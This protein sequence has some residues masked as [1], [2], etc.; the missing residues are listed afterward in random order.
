MTF[1]VEETYVA[2]YL[3]KV[4]MTFNSTIFSSALDHLVHINRDIEGNS[5]VIIERPN[6]W[7]TAPQPILG[8]NESPEGTSNHVGDVD[9]ILYNTEKYS[10]A[11]KQIGEVVRVTIILHDPVSNIKT[12]LTPPRVFTNEA[13]NSFTDLNPI[14]ANYDPWLR[15]TDYSSIHINYTRSTSF[16]GLPEIHIPYMLVLE[17]SDWIPPYEITTITGPYE[18]YDD[19]YRYGTPENWYHPSMVSNNIVSSGG[20]AWGPYP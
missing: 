19:F 4:D 2:N 8:Q 12:A 5:T 15:S 18:Y 13:A 9:V 16:F 7:P 11:T 6:P 20:L 1:K 17:Y 10:Y 14:L 3:T